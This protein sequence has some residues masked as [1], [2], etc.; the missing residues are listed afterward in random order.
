VSNQLQYGN[1][2]AWAQVQAANQSLA[3]PEPLTLVQIIQSIPQVLSSYWGL[4]GVEL[5]FPAWIDIIFYVGLALALIG[6]GVLAWRWLNAVRRA[7]WN[8]VLSGA[9]AP[10]LLLLVWESALLGSYVLWLRAYIGTENSRLIFPGIA[11]VACAM[12][13]GWM[14][15]TPRRVRRAVGLA[16]CAGLTALSALTPFLL[17]TPAFAT[18]V[19]LT[20]QQQAA[21]PGQTGVTF[22][23]KIH[24]Q[25]AQINQRSVE[26]GE[27]LSVSLFWGAL[28]PLNQSYH[29]ILAARDAQG[30]MIG[31]LEA[32]PYAGRFDTQRWEPGKLFRDDYLLPIDAT[33]QRGIATIELSVREVYEQ[34]PLLPVDGAK[35]NQFVVGRFKVLGALQAAPAPQTPFQATFAS[36]TNKLIQLQGYDL[37][38]EGDRRTLMLHWLCLAQP[39][40]DYT[41]FVHVLDSNGTIIA[42]QDAQA[43]NG[44]YPTSMWD[45]QEQ[46]VDPRDIELPA[47]ASSLRI[48]WYVPGDARLKAFQ[49]DGSAWP[50]DAVVIPLAEAH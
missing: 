28:S 9:A 24:L 36:G 43:L 16:V 48:G 3:R 11:L 5:H 19:Y 8:A 30:Q 26:P 15:L 32:I 45:A 2:L 25:H 1:P 29:V 27:P 17:I 6:C 23:G 7:G 20:A 13:A 14:A 4:I 35:V 21:L 44:A 47:S 12:A 50:D 38:M 42:Q 31:R 40:R 41:L 37:Q 46:I 10:V 34:P 49:A 18:P 22:G 33:A 39:D